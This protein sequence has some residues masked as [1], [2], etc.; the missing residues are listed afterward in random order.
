MWTAADGYELIDK[1]HLAY[2]EYQ[3]S[4]AL[5]AVQCFQAG[6]LE[7]SKFLSDGLPTST[8][9]WTSIS[10]G[11]D[12]A[13]KDI[14]I[15][16]KGSEWIHQVPEHI[17]YRR[18]VSHGW[19][20]RNGG[21][22]RKEREEGWAAPCPPAFAAISI[23]ITDNNGDKIFNILADWIEESDNG[24]ELAQQ[25]WVAGGFIKPS[26]CR[27]LVSLGASIDTRL[28]A[29]HRT[30]LQIA[31]ALWEHDVVN[32]LIELGAD[33][34]IQT[35]DKR[36]ALHWFLCGPDQIFRKASEMFIRDP[37]ARLSAENKNR[38]RKT[39]IVSTIEALCRGN[40]TNQ[41]AVND[42]SPLMISARNSP[43]ATQTLLKEGAPVD[44]KDYWGR[45]ALM[46]FFC[47]QFCGRPSKILT[48]LLEARADALAT[49]AS[50]HTVLQYWARQLFSMDL[51]SLYPGYN[52]FNKSFDAMTSTGVL[53]DDDVLIQEIC[54][55]DIPL[56]AAV[57]LGNTRLCWALLMSGA[58]ANKHGLTK[59]TRLPEGSGSDSMDLED[60]HWKPLLVA[61][62]HKAYS[63]A[64][65][66]IAHGADVAY[67]T[68]PKKR[69][70]LNKYRIKMCGIT[71]LHLVAGLP[72]RGHMPT[73]NTGGRDNC[74]FCAVGNTNYKI[75][76]ESGL[77]RLAEYSRKQWEESWS[78][79]KR[80]KDEPSDVSLTLM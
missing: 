27:R 4:S 31:A 41:A 67:K 68:P 71:A 51:G 13:L 59:K 50:G 73:L 70:R 39:R 19:S 9:I 54:R 65:L 56:A 20:S 36:T 76:K 33:S 44:Q 30:A 72:D 34:T 62:K 57:Q 75:T 23:A 49:D 2:G 32:T 43:T 80:F 26:F 55:L 22:L 46:H 24:N 78:H 7:R 61:L 69:S 79:Q 8:M 1:Y 11:A 40:S 3:Y 25:L 60:L 66:L 35:A 10:E 42:V 52:R 77:A 63:T 12:N 47:G 21:D 53:L 6:Q 18:T 37:Y 74:S 58:D 38:Q 5:R 15:D 48:H 45:T 17:M 28:W 29:E 14:L 64:A 16:I